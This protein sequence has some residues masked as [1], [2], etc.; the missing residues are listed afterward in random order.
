V[1]DRSRESHRSHRS[2]EVEGARSI[3]EMSREENGRDR[4][5]R[6]REMLEERREAVR[7]RDERFEVS[8][9]VSSD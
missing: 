6:D 9:M 5:R 2:K 4:E 7:R 3:R 1:R 8:W